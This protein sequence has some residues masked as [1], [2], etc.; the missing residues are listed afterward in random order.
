MDITTMVGAS[1]PTLG[2]C[3][4]PECDKPKKLNLKGQPCGRGLCSMHYERLRKHGS[5]SVRGTGGVKRKDDV[6]Y[7]QMHRRV[8]ADRGRIT[9]HS[10]TECGKQAR[11]WAYD[12]SDPSPLEQWIP[13]PNGKMHLAAYSTDTARYQPMCRGCHIAFDAERD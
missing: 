10:C 2:V 8:R 6:T 3:C 5:T 9:E 11:D 4:E 7:K 1:A 13:L 12:H